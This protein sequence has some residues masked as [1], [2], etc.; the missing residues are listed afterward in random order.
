[1]L[2][3]YYRNSSKL[4][5]F[6][7]WAVS[8]ILILIMLEQSFVM[9][10][11]ESGG[12]DYDILQMVEKRTGVNNFIRNV[13]F[14]ILSFFSEA[15]DYFHDAV[16]T[17]A[18]MNLYTLF[19]SSK[20]NT[21]NIYPL[22]WTLF[23]LFLIIMGVIFIWN[24]DKI[25]ISESAKSIIMSAIMIVAMPTFFSSLSDMKSAGISDVEGSVR[26]ALILL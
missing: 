14:N 23:S 22:A 2:S 1:M 4:R 15:I 11:A 26:T 7:F 10:S 21:S 17:L 12:I 18:N 13:K 6:T 25:K 19:I 16:N 3:V 24:N 20:F 8:L 9:I 5:K